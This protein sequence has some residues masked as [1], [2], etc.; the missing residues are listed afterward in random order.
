L[1]W[2]AGSKSPVP[3]LVTQVLLPGSLE[4][5]TEGEALD[6]RAGD[7]ANGDVGFLNALRVVRRNVEQEVD[8]RSEVPASVAGEGD[9]VSF[10]GATRFDAAHNVRALAAGGESDEN[11]IG[12]DQGFDL[13][14]EN[15]LEAVIVGGRRQ[16]GRVSRKS[17]SGQ[18]GTVGAKAN[19]QFSSK[20]NGV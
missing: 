1:R 13:P 3:S 16:D 14:R 8:L 6:Q 11:V 15:V 12:G 18:P 20:V 7:V 5:S 17:Q 9:H 10:A 2:T 4:R 19:N